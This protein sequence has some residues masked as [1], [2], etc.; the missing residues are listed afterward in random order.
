MIEHFKNQIDE[1]A[2][3][4]FF[5]AL[6]HDGRMSIERHRGTLDTFPTLVYVRHLTEGIPLFHKMRCM[7]CNEVATDI[8]ST[9]FAGDHPHCEDHAKRESD[10]NQNDSYTQW[11][12]V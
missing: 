7:Y 11:Y 1:G 4:M 5:Y 10:Y 12:K 6:E 3:E 9:Q 2:K 8:R